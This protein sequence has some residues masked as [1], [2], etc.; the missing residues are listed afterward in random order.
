MPESRTPRLR[1]VDKVT[2]PYPLNEFPK[3]FGVKVGKEIIYL[4]AT[5]DQV[6]LEGTEWEKIFADCIGAEWKNSVVGLDDVTLGSCAWGAK[7]VKNNSPSTVKQVRLISGRNDPLFSFGDKFARGDPSAKGEMVLSIWNER[8]SAV[9]LKHKHVRTIVLIKGNG[10][11]E[12]CIFEFD[13]VRY[14]PEL[15]E[16][17]W[18]REDG[19]GNLEGFLK[20]TRTHCFTWQPG[21]KQFTIKEKVPEK[22]LLIS[23]KTPPKLDREGVFKTIEYEDNWITVTERNLLP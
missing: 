16:W 13:T 19:T 12:V 8:V 7:T 17:E 5:K 6:S 20:G 14:D 3:N 1:T 4:L 22:C 10:L 2:P 23:L 11:S 21:G 18:N 15:Y 9:R